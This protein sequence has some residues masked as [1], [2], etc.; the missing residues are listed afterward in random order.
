M[1]AL[2]G[3][4]TRK[5]HNTQLS[6]RYKKNMQE[7]KEGGRGGGGVMVLPSIHDTE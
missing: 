2:R 5:Q 6:Q 4:S 3:L 1:E 7:G